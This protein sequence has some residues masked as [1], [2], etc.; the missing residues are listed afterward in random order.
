MML[1]QLLGRNAADKQALDASREVDVRQA[2]DARSAGTAQ[3]VDVRE[4]D[5]WAEGHIPGAIHIPLAILA[6]QAANLDPTRPVITVCRSGNRSLVALK[7]LR[8]AGFTDARSLAG[9][10][11]AWQA[12][13]QPVER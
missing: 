4:P 8:A 5:E 9:G 13:G 6:R 1:R 10:M 12:A 7:P 11:K 3:I 2:A